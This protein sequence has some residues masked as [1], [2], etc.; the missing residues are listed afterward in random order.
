MAHTPDYVKN[1]WESYGDSSKLVEV[2]CDD[3]AR[4]GSLAVHT[5]QT[6]N[7]PISSS[8]DTGGNLKNVDIKRMDAMAVINLSLLEAT[9]R[10]G[11]RRGE[12][13]ELIINSAGEA[14][15]IIVG[16]EAASL[17]DIYYQVQ[18]DSYRE[19]CSGVLI[20]GGVTLPAWKELDWKPVWGEGED[21]TKH[22][23]DTTVMAT[24]C[25]FSNYSTHVTI[26]Y[27]DPNLTNSTYN[28]G[29]NNL[30]EVENPFDKIVGHVYF[31][32]APDSTIDTQ[33]NQANTCTVPIQLGL[34]WHDGNGPDMGILRPRP[35]VGEDATRW[36]ECWAG[37]GANLGDEINFA[38]DAVKIPLPD[39]MRFEDIRGT[40]V[41]KLVKIERILIIGQELSL[42]HT[43]AT[44][45]S[46]AAQENP[47]Q[48]NTV[49]VISMNDISLKVVELEEGKHYVIAYE[50]EDGVKQP[51][52]VFAKDARV[53]EP[54]DYGMGS[55][56]MFAA[57]DET[58]Y[59]QVGETGIGTIF[60]V[61]ENKGYIVNQIWAMVAL[62]SPCITVFDPAFNDD[63]ADGTTSLA[64]TIAETLEYVVAPII[65][66]E[67]PA[68]IVFS[69]G[70]GA[71]VVDQI[72]SQPDTDPTTTQD[73][74]DTPLEIIMDE[75]AG[76]PGLEVTLSF[77]K[78][79]DEAVLLD[80][81]ENLYELIN[82]DYVET[83]Y[84]CGPNTEVGLGEKGPAGGI[85]NNISYSYSDNGSYTISVN[86]GAKISGNFGGGGGPTGPSFKVSESANMRGTVIDSIGNGMF[87]KV[88]IDGYGER[89]A[90]NMA[91][92][93]V[94]VGD[95]VSCSIHNNPVED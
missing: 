54:K 61:A 73:F 26:T 43:G 92:V 8:S 21:S 37:T 95:V 27:D 25:M 49:T 48:E 93:F 71:E 36:A 76:G 55:N 86:E 10:E 78:D 11:L 13:F 63:T 89:V 24:N 85:I 60:P 51:Y 28:D 67:I 30:Y 80:L 41:D 23:Y 12:I 64:K 20:Y 3:A 38:A 88:R 39:K 77:L 9:A 84:V 7:I 79:E 83:T 87:F 50:I 58:G 31:I 40:T 6:F 42:L 53:N 94:R 18:S 59:Y 34:E 65:V 62:D 75:L 46:T 70:Y 15:F 5:L 22:P 32:H 19:E 74:T 44:T 29:I 81:V 72:P 91:N 45:D 14:E 90:I 2:E 4:G 57:S 68:P 69:K 35:S 52:V 17:N 56:Y 82:E 66:E 47:N 33:I 16:Q 1:F